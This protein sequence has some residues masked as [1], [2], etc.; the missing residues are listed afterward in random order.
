MNKKSRYIEIIIHA[1]VWAV[2]YFL[3]FAFSMGSEEDLKYVPFHFWLHLSLVG[4]IFYA[5]YGYLVDKLLFKS[6]YRMF[7]FVGNV[8]LLI[9]MIAV[10]SE[11]YTYM[12]PNQRH[13]PGPPQQLA[14]YMDFLAYLIP[15]AVAV[16]L[17]AGKRALKV[18]ALKAEA[19]N[20]R[21]QSELQHLKFQFQPH[22]VFNALNNVYALIEVNPAKAQQS[23]HSLS[24][25]MRH[26]IQSSEVAT[27]TLE[28]EMDFLLK[29]IDVMRL[30][31]SSQVVIDIDF[32]KEV[33]PVRVV[34]LL[35]I[36]LVENA[37][38]HGIA[39][40]KPSNI[41]FELR[42]LDKGKISFSSSNPFFPKQEE[43]L[44]RS[45]IGLPNLK[46]RLEI[47][48]PD[49]FKLEDSLWENR[50][51]IRLEIPTIITSPS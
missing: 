29:Y 36:T 1:L 32:P 3:P 14:W 2:L 18:E 19:E 45:G 24:R 35:F 51:F 42:V 5:N 38:K 15:V 26:L 6:S 50:Y 8:A 37:F 47:L 12:V 17:K 10:K 25:L 11:L 23:L 20:K 39:A 40:G 27:I 46:K 44:S 49:Q 30:R 31:L 16:A 43:D 41:H 33:P 4:V 9:G 28:E 22:F 21:L 13:G 7:F 48:Y 34:P